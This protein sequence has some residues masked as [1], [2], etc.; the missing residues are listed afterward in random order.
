MVE[1]IHSTVSLSSAS[2]TWTGISVTH[3]F[4][5]RCLLWDPM[6]Y[7]LRAGGGGG[8]VGEVYTIIDNSSLPTSALELQCCFNNVLF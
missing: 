8:G 1:E 7:C 4:S 2:L 3:Y 6:T 5:P